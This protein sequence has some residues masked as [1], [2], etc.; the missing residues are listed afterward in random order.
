MSSWLEFPVDTYLDRRHR[1]WV[2]AEEFGDVRF[3]GDVVL[4]DPVRAE[5]IARALRSGRDVGLLEEVLALPARTSFG[6][7]RLPA[8]S[9]G[10]HA[11]VAA[12]RAETITTRSRRR[13]IRGWLGIIAGAAVFVA[14]LAM[15]LDDAALLLALALVARG[16]D[17]AHGASGET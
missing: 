16:T 9:A 4:V 7:V 8:E 14:A 13:D 3:S 17:H 1:N 12:P 2:L 15:P 6:V 10:G 11:R 5:H